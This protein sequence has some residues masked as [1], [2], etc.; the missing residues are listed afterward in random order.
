MAYYINQSGDNYG[1]YTIDQLRSMW[2]AGQ[3]T[4]DTLYCE[5]GY[6][7][8]LQLSALLDAQEQPPLLQPTMIARNRKPL[9]IAGVVSG[10]LI[11]IYIFVEMLSLGSKPIATVQQP[12]PPPALSDQPTS[13]V[14]SRSPTHTAD[15]VSETVTEDYAR[16][17]NAFASKWDMT[18]EAVIRLDYVFTR[19][20]LT[21]ADFDEA[22]AKLDRSR[23]I[24]LGYH[25]NIPK[26]NANGRRLLV[27][28]TKFPQN[29]AIT[30]DE[31]SIVKTLKL[32]GY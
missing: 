1:P 24:A 19:R 20:N 17:I 13:S 2:S 8:W 29:P 21:L 10:V 25:P 23:D 9:M 18:V 3:V 11:V 27:G 31:E 16:R 6:K 15:A 32:A 14:N 26:R 5:E 22:L 7:E 30:K 28:E 12:T 4:C